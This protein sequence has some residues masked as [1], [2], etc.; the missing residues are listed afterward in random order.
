MIRTFVAAILLALASGC[1][2]TKGSGDPRDPWEPMNRATFGLNESLDH[3]ILK[4]TAEA[5][6]RVVPPFA[7]TGIN[8]F[9]ENIAD[10]W[11]AA[12]QFLQGKPAEGFND[13]GRVLC[14]T[15]LGVGGFIDVA[16]KMEVEKHNEDFGQTL[17]WWGV[18]SGP[19]FVIPLLG[20]STARDAP[21]RFVDPSW[22]YNRAIDNSTATWSLWGLDM[23][24]TRA[25]LLKAGSIMEE[26][27]IDRYSFVRDLWLQRRRS[28]V[29][30][31][32]PPK[33][34]DEE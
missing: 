25:N 30:D 9:F 18:P 4:P 11:T 20:P 10:V 3:A 31:G 1:A 12:N 29:Y 21:A 23:L 24:R 32:R 26:A 27:A 33:E 22:Y 15:T 28:Q 13:L 17:G 5:Y 7:R 16:S 6:V 14:N 19:Y 34:K 8:N 2:T